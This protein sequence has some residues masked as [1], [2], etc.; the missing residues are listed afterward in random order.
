M[1]DEVQ[2]TAVKVP[3]ASSVSEQLQPSLRQR[4]SFW[5]LSEEMFPVSELKPSRAL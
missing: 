4:P 1:F 3:R 2:A 5:L